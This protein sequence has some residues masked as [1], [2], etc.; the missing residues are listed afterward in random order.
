MDRVTLR[1]R[2]EQMADDELLRRY[3]SG[4]M[5]DEAK[6]VAL[7]ELRARALIVGPAPLNAEAAAEE[8]GAGVDVVC[9]ARLLV[10]TDA[11]ILCGLLEAEGI[12]TVAGDAHLVQ[13]NPFLTMAVGGVRVLVYER[14]LARAR[15]ILRAWRDGDYALSEDERPD[16]SEDEFRPT[17][18][19]CRG[20]ERVGGCSGLLFRSTPCPPESSP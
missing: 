9:L 15:E 14:D 3:R 4:D 13:A 8:S 18:G 10:P 6:E 2:F 17:H 5:T 1:Q 7:D 12:A 20:M 16:G 11:H 19:I